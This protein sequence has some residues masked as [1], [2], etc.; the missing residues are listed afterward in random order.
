M[1]GFGG[2]NLMPKKGSALGG[3]RVGYGVI[4]DL[5]VFLEAGMGVTYLT[6][7]QLIF[8][9]IVILVDTQVKAQYYAWKGLYLNAG[10]G[11]VITRFSSG[12]KVGIGTSA[13]IGYEFRIGKLFFIAPEGRVEYI[14]IAGSN[15]LPIEAGVQ[16][17]FHF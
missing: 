4:E 6:N 11:P 14:R 3:V 17:G 2:M 16:L 1:I 12:T 5:I 9:D 15:I 13:G 10:A 7:Q 8:P